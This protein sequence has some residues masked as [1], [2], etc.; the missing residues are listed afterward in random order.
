MSEITSVKP[1]ELY[2]TAI[3]NEIEEPNKSPLSVAFCSWGTVIVT[4]IAS[5]FGFVICLVTG[6]DWVTV[7]PTAVIE[8][9]LSMPSTFVW[10]DVPNLGLNVTSWKL[11]SVVAGEAELA[12]ALRTGVSFRNTSFNAALLYAV[13]PFVLP[14]FEAEAKPSISPSEIR[15]RKVANCLLCKVSGALVGWGEV[16]DYHHQNLE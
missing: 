5:T 11:K 7:T 2:W 14:S 12:V 16:E 9:L 15:S 8:E 10:P 1:P 3:F 6:E 4:F 13:V